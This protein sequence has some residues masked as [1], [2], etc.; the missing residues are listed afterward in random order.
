M[1][2]NKN[3]EIFNGDCLEIMDKLIEDNVKV[4]MILTDPPYGIKYQN[5]YTLNKHKK[6]INDDVI[7][8]KT[9]GEKAMQF[10]SIVQNTLNVQNEKAYLSPDL[11]GYSYT[12][13]HIYRI[14][15]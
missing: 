11:L 12:I 1:L 8:Y 10:H 9:F 15:S 6:I 5:N 14:I 7:D 4:D 2:D 3:Y 13:Q